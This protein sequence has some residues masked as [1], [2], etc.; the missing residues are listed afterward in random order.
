VTA[1][2]A[3]VW[4]GGSTLLAAWFAAAAGPSLAPDTHADPPT[5]QAPEPDR[6]ALRLAAE[7]ERLNGRLS[8]V[9]APPPVRRNPFLFASKVQV[10]GRAPD[11]AEPVAPPAVAAAPPVTLLGVAEDTNGPSLVRTAILSIR[12]ELLLVKEGELV[13]GRY[14]IAAIDADAVEL[15]DTVESR[16]IRIV[17]P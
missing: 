6:A 17:L 14:R 15:E 10:A 12:G 1:R 13:S 2:R 16:T 9:V 4:L 11:A 8:I 7:A 5:Y 3:A